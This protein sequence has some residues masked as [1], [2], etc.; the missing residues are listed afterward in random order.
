MSLPAGARGWSS[1]DGARGLTR[2]LNGREDRTMVSSSGLRPAL[3]RLYSAGVADTSI[4]LEQISLLV[5]LK[6]LS[7]R[8]SDKV[9]WSG[10][11]PK[12]EPLSGSGVLGRVAGPGDPK[13]ARP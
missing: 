8:G 5:L 9:Y 13:G 7:L 11:P 6:W 10:G 1:Y 4:A 3:D 12:V 2:A